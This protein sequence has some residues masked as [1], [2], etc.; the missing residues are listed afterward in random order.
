MTLLTLVAVLSTLAV[1]AVLIGSFTGG[2]VTV[3]GVASSTVTYSPDNALPGT[4][5]TTLTPSGVSDP[6]YTRLEIS[7]GDYSGPVTVTWQLQKKNGTSTWEDVSGADVITTMLLAGT[8]ENVYASNDG[9]NT[10]NYDWSTDV[11]T[12]G[13]YR[14]A[15]SVDSS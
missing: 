9:G 14:V 1:T 6:W 10:G 7:A 5:T 4:W 8:A 13:T 3:G 12:S 2:E 15:V 11:S